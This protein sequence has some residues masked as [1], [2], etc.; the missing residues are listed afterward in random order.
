VVPFSVA[1]L[2]AFDWHTHLA[3]DIAPA[4]GRPARA[5]DDLAMS[6]TLEWMLAVL[7]QHG[8]TQRTW[9]DRSVTLRL[10]GPGGGVWT[11]APRAHGRLNVTAGS[12]HAAAT[13][14]GSAADL[15][16]WA[17]TRTAWNDHD[18]TISGDRDY[19]TRFLDGVNII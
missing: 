7:A 1:R 18:L 19:A 12:G 8:G 3:H 5:L 2:L 11:L 4:I 15:P 13:I 6:V 10:T 9:M 14:T 16:S 17:T